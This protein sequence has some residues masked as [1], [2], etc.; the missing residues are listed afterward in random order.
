MVVDHIFGGHVYVISSFTVARNPIFKDEEDVK[1]FQTNI[2][3]YLG[4]ICDINAY[5]HSTDH[6]QY[7][8]TVKERSVLEDFFKRKEEKKMKGRKS[9]RT[10]KKVFIPESYQ[11]FSQQFSNC[12]NSYVKKYNFRHHRKGALFARR[13]SKYLVE[14]KSEMLE[15]IR[16]LNNDKAVSIYDPEWRVKDV[17]KLEKDSYLR[18]SLKYYMEEGEVEERLVC[19]GLEVS[20]V[21]LEGKLRG[22]F[23]CHPPRNIKSP[24]VAHLWK[25]YFLKMGKAPPW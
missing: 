8:I 19:K 1:Q 11:I 4:E 7:L 13:Y 16:L 14:T 9:S 17:V 2:Q 10:K 20:K 5:R 22:C 18:C 15:W 25:D 24:N 21:G 12:L 6:F 3:K 23:L